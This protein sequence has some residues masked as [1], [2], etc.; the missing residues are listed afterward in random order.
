M[1]LFIPKL[2]KVLVILFL[3][4]IISDYNL[5]VTLAALFV[6]A[7]NL[8]SWESDN[9]TFTLLYSDILY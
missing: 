8:S 4:R 2:F 3:I 1:Y 6:A 7:I 5:R 9:L